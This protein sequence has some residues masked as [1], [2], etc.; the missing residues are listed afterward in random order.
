MEPEPSQ[1]A[2]QSAPGAVAS[3]ATPGE[4]RKYP[5]M[6]LLFCGICIA[7]F[8]G[9]LSERNRYSWE[10]L[11]AWGC[12]TPARIRTGALWGFVSSSFIHLEL[13]HVAFNVYWLYVLGSR[14][15]R[16]IGSGRWLA[17]ILAAAFLSSGAQFAFSDSTGI[18][19]SGVVYAIHVGDQASATE[20]PKGA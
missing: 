2:T 20:F 5:I 15:E 19:A 7:V 8:L 4:R 18:G 9:L 13:W 3:V 16:V 1:P 14:L 17:F 12:Y 10:T 6:T 11:E